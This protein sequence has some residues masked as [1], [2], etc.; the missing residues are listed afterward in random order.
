MTNKDKLQKLVEDLSESEAAEA[1]D[2][3]EWLLADEDSLSAEELA[4]V[5][6]GEGELAR[7]ERVSWDEVKREL[8]L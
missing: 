4:E 6:A 1:I 5:K 7:G 3:V 2:F 8:G